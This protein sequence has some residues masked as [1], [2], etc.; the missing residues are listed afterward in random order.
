MILM[1]SFHAVKVPIGLDLE[2]L[3]HPEVTEISTCIFFDS[4][5]LLLLM[6]L[7][8]IRLDMLCGCGV[9]KGP[10]SLSCAFPASFIE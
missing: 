8:L 3:F 1:E 6:F 2:I 7:F 10:G 9:K 4:F 5:K